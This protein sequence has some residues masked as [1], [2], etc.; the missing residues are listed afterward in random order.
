[1]KKSELLDTLSSAI[2]SGTVNTLLLH[3]ETPANKNE[4]TIIQGEQD[5]KNKIEYIDSAYDESLRLKR[6]D[7]VNIK[8]YSFGDANSVGFESITWALFRQEEDRE[9]TEDAPAEG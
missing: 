5:V 1:M 4:V 9:L 2:N 6:N 8:N 3:I 7:K